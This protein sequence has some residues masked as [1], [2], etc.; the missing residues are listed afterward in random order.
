MDIVDYVKKPDILAKLKLKNP[1]SL[2]TAQCWMKYVGYCWSKAPTGQFV[3][4][5][6]QS[7]VVTYRQLVFLPIW[8]ELL[9]LT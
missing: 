3:N 4:G 8:A 9:S 1:I 6:K 7:D 2:T 5:H